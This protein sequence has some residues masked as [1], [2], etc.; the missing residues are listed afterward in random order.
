[1]GAA[2]TLLAVVT[3]CGAQAEPGAEVAAQQPADHAPVRVGLTEWTI[4]V[5]RSQVPTGKL[6]LIV[7]NAGATTHDLV[8]R[9]RR[10]TWE[11]PD[12]APGERARLTVRAAPHETLQLWCSMPGHRAQ[13]MHTTLTTS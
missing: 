11:T 2:A 3:G 12:L 4:V 6:R 8:V 7:T 5:S 9:G 10:G 1:V 13:G